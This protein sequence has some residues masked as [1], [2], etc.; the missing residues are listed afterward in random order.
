MPKT[1]QRNKSNNKSKKNPLSHIPRVTSHHISQEFATLPEH[2][3]PGNFPKLGIL[4]E[5]HQNA[6]P[7]GLHICTFKSL[8][9]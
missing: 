1:K 3:S 4:H 5:G 2:Q 8:N 9:K 6:K 7:L